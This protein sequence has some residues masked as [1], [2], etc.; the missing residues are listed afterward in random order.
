MAKARH[1]T[2][3]A[4]PPIRAVI[5]DLGGVVLGSPLH[6][7]ADF[8]REHDLPPGFVNRVVVETGA[9]GA[10]A[11]HERGEVQTEIF[12]EEFAREC[13]SAGHALSVRLT[14]SGEEL[15]A[16]L[17]DAERHHLL[18][19]EPEGLIE[20]WS[21]REVIHGPLST[22]AGLVVVSDGAVWLLRAEPPQRID[23]ALRY[24]CLS[25]DAAGA[26]V[27]T[28]TALHTL[29]AEQGVGDE[30]WNLTQLGGPPQWA[31]DLLEEVDAEACIG[32]WMEFGVHAGL[33]EPMSGDVSDPGAASDESGCSQANAPSHWTTL[34]WLL[35]PIASVRSSR[36][37]RTW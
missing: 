33:L 19:V 29:D 26:F 22:S 20:L 21:R 6:A 36:G 24:R 18:R 14:V 11:R 1:D 10:W 2:A 4:R 12:M 30:V 3:S 31:T 13:S 34:L 17:T 8:E 32:E 23:D 5:F 9:G 7:I 16:V 27:C 28:R 35:I 37:R 15:Y 25:G